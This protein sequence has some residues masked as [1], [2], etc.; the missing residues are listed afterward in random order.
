V[1]AD[2]LASILGLRDAKGLSGPSRNLRKLLRASGL[3]WDDVVIYD[4]EPRIGRVWRAGPK[5]EEAIAAI[6]GTGVKRKKIAEA[7]ESRKGKEGKAGGFT[8]PPD[9]SAAQLS[10]D[11]PADDLP[12]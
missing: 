11:M 10:R 5:I 3:E 6:K 4:R 7:A 12:F 2:E 9:R 8:P 1:S